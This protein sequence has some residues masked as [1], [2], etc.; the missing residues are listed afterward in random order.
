R[1]GQAEHVSN[2]NLKLSAKLN[3]RTITVHIVWADGT[4]A[5]DVHAWSAP[6]G[7]VP[8]QRLETDAKGRITFPAMD[9]LA[10]NIGAAA[11]SDYEV[12]SR[13]GYSAKPVSVPP[14]PS[15][16]VRIVLA[17]PPKN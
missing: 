5:G 14:G 2:M 3:P 11:E 12:P 6:V 16:S 13:Q 7:Y 8:W 17:L 9:G 4:P 10:Y 1:V 15:A